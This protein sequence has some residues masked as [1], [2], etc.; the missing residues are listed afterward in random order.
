MPNN[1]PVICGEYPGMKRYLIHLLATAAIALL[2]TPL[3]VAQNNGNPGLPNDNITVVSV[4]GRSALVTND[5]GKTWRWVRGSEGENA[6]DKGV[7]SLRGALYGASIPA[8]IAASP[9]PATG[10]VVIPLKSSLNGQVEFRLYDSRGTQT[11]IQQLDA[12]SSQ[13]AIQYNT[14]LLPNGMYSFS[15]HCGGAMAG[16]GRIVVAH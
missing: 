13:Q 7:E 16:V 2:A 1:V 11:D 10:I 9:D 6:Y 4:E 5:G 8:P 15:I 12:T 3:L 14:A